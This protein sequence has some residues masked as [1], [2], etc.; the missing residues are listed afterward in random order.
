MS[1]SSWWFQPIWKILYSQIGSFPQ[2]GGRIKHI[3]NHHLV[4]VVVFIARFQVPSNSDQSFAQKLV[5]FYMEHLLQGCSGRDFGWVD[6]DKKPTP[7][8]K[9][10]SSSTW[11]LTHFY[12]VVKCVWGNKNQCSNALCW[13]FSVVVVDVFAFS[14]K[15]PMN[16]IPHIASFFC[17][18]PSIHLFHLQHLQS[19]LP[20][21]RWGNE[22]TEQP[23][24]WF[25]GRMLKESTRST[26]YSSNKNIKPR[27]L[28]RGPLPVFFRRILTPLI[29]RG[30]FTPFIKIGSG[31]ILLLISR[32]SKNPLT[33]TQPHG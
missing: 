32:I 18:G 24:S 13:I 8:D 31:P 3:W 22:A 5:D 11:S 25:C 29:Y 7:N 28:Q 2:V 16:K 9:Q 15:N 12:I 17:S 27:S 23:K 21:T 33:P 19:P 6:S 10:V 4:F 30:W 14:Y 20:P 26:R 1:F